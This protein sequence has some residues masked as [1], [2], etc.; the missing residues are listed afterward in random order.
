MEETFD[1]G[2]AVQRLRE[3]KSVGRKDPQWAGMR[4]CLAQVATL[5]QN[6]ILAVRGP[7]QQIQVQ[8]WQPTYQDILADDYYLA[9]Q[10]ASVKTIP[11]LSLT[12]K[13]PEQ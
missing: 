2:W 7:V 13:N 6:M 5:E 11:P 1:I 4:L 9:E 10:E 3:G 8:F 12:K